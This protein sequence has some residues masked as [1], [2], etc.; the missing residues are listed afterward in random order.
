VDDV[1]PVVRQDRVERRID[2]GEHSFRFWLNAGPADARLW[3]V[4][5]EATARHEPPMALVAFPPGNA[6]P[7]AAG[8]TL[9][10]AVVQMPAL[11]LSEDGRALIV[12]LFEPTGRARVTTL[13]VPALGVA[14]T[15][16]LGPFE[17]RTLAVDLR[18]RSVEDCDL[19]ER[20][21]TR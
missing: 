18:T 7:A 17:L 12:R 15:V 5:R 13:A 8:V 21:V 3:A 14:A 10:D 20:Q 1:T 4:D 6:R 2:Q 19:L 16:D 9:S 11:K